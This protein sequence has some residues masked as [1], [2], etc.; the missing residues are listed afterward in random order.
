MHCRVVD[1]NRWRRISRIIQHIKTN[2]SFYRQ[3]WLAKQIWNEVETLW[4]T[5]HWILASCEYLT[6]CYLPDSPLVPCLL[7]VPCILLFTS[8][9]SYLRKQ[10]T[11]FLVKSKSAFVIFILWFFLF[12]LFQDVIMIC[13]YFLQI[14]SYN[15]NCEILK[16]YLGN[17]S[18]EQLQF[19]WH[20]TALHLL[21]I[22]K[23][24]HYAT[25]Y[26]HFEAVAKTVKF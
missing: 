17:E 24:K 8:D 11:A 12:T 26:G 14:R 5:A 3:R 19:D 25:R 16:F 4:D 6:S 1:R 9:G 23:Y 13:A 22:C 7:W 2:V 18:Q 15:K 21:L 20:F 10:K